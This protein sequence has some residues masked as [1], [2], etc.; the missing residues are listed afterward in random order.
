MDTPPSF[1]HAFSALLPAGQDRRQASTAGPTLNEIALSRRRFI[2]ASLATSVLF[3][4][5][6]CGANAAPATVTRTFF[7]A[8]EQRF[9]EAATARLIPGDSADP[10]ALEAGVPRFIDLQLSGPFGRADR[11]YRQGPWS[12]GTEQQGYQLEETPA[13]L[14]RKA[15]AAIDAYCREQYQG[16]S[17]AELPEAQQD[18]ILHDLEDGKLTVKDVPVKAFFTLLLQ[19]TQEGFLADPMYGG[20]R[21]FAG[22]NLIGF[23]GPRYN[24]VKEVRQYGQPYS[25]PTV[26]LQGRRDTGART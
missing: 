16:K 2:T 3:A 20:N 12:Q 19:N 14:Y 18:Q 4:L 11:W 17:Y 13:E 9:I 26:G 8:D 7:S 1:G 10:G 15:I 23:P 25:L 22:W 21:D 24:Y 5:Q 6:G